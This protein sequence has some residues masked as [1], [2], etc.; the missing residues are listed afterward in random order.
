[1][2]PVP[3]QSLTA[4]LCIA[5]LVM[6]ARA[7]SVAPPARDQAAQLSPG[8]VVEVHLR[9]GSTQKG[10]VVSQGQDSFE[11]RQSDFFGLAPKPQNIPYNNV[12]L[13]GTPLQVK[14]WMMRMGDR[15]TVRL[16]AGTEI[17]GTLIS[18][19]LVSFLMQPEVPKGVTSSSSA[20]SLAY[21]DV[22]TAKKVGHPIRNRLIVAGVVLGA[23]M[24]LTAAGLCKNEGN[25]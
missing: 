7:Q 23:L 12:V 1:M 17:K 14:L 5:L 13:V 2:K 19:G 21:Q 6:P 22:E 24:A 8:A 15:V 11:L 4:T 3:L 16:R 25:C 9:G 10:T 20:V 18:A